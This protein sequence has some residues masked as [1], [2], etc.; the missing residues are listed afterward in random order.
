MRDTRTPRVFFAALAVLVFTL[1]P[2]YG[3]S[4]QGAPHS[5]VAAVETPPCTRTYPCTIPA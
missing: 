3:T 4:P 2:I 5:G 1:S